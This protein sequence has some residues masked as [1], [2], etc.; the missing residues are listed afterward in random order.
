MHLMSELHKLVGTTLAL[1][2]STQAMYCNDLG[3]T[4][5][6]ADHKTR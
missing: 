5:S 2:M 1:A 3:T 6:T 4:F